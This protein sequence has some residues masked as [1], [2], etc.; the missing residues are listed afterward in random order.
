MRLT[1]LYIHNYKSF[2]DTTIELDKLNIVVGENN[3][4]KSNLIDV[5]E[6]I[7]IVLTKNFATAFE[8]K[9]GWE[10]IYNYNNDESQMLIE[11]ELSNNDYLKKTRLTFHEDYF[12]DST[13]NCRKLNNIILPFSVISSRASHKKH[14]EKTRSYLFQKNMERIN[15]LNVDSEIGNLL[16]YH[17]YILE[18]H[19][20]TTYTFNTETIRNKSH[21]R[22]EKE[23]QKNGSNLGQNLLY[24][25][26][27]YPDS[28]NLI[29]NSMIGVVNEIKGIDVQETFGNALI[30]FKERNKEIGIDM[31]SDG[32]IN[33][34][35]TITA[36]NQDED[37]FII[38][39]FDEPERYLHMKAV[40]YLM[41][42]FRSSKKQILI[43]THSTEILK[44]AD[45][46][47]V[48][49]IYRDSDGDTQSIRADEIP[50]LK[51]KMEH[52]TYE[53][54]MTLD[55]MLD[56]DMVWDFE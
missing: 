15:L 19:L 11:F 24:I 51:E 1:K 37:K 28:F 14:Q 16:S 25:K 13:F 49:F 4:G 22:A 38:L 36:L 18:S 6:F 12:I 48:I 3:S 46:S 55:E 33:L 20:S 45:L 44:Y 52:M 10:K 53:R 31:V 30:G 23:L 26:S 7:D 50:N 47:E 17:T 34:L 2:Y 27:N 32:T 9:G 8:E 35:A 43:T 39:A 5:L 21:R 56:E 42:S 40:H 29:S 54:S 41:D